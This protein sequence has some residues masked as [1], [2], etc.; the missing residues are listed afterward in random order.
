MDADIIS[1]DWV[2]FLVQ[3]SME[4]HVVGGLVPSASRSNLTQ[5]KAEQWSQRTPYL[6]GPIQMAH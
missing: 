3:G 1:G 4:L 2:T 5:M 6:L